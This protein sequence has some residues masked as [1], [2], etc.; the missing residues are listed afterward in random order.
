MRRKAKRGAA[1]VLSMMLALGSVNAPLYAQEQTE[2]TTQMDAGTT[3][4]SE[5][6]EAESVIDEVEEKIDDIERKVSIDG[7]VLEVHRLVGTLECS[8]RPQPLEIATD[9]HYRC[10]LA[11]QL[12]SEG[13]SDE[14]AEIIISRNPLYSSLDT[15]V[16]IGAGLIILHDKLL[17]GYTQGTAERQ[18]D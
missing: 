14:R 16:P 9:T 12:N 3:L 11:T 8:L 1:F 2:A 7:V 18:C 17:S 6:Q 4:P 10:H 13:R 5:E 15:T